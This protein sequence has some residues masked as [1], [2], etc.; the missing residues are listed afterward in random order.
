MLGGV[1][2]ENVDFLAFWVKFYTINTIFKAFVSFP[3]VSIAF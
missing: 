1:Q 3:N 2:Y